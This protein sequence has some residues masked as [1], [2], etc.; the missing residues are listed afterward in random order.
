MAA[1]A[2]DLYFLKHFSFLLLEIYAYFSHLVPPSTTLSLWTL[3]Q[4]I[5]LIFFPLLLLA[6]NFPHHFSDLLF[7]V[8]LRSLIYFNLLCNLSWIH[9]PPLLA[10]SFFFYSIWI[11]LWQ[12]GGFP[13]L[14]F[15]NLPM[16]ALLFSDW[17][18]CDRFPL[19]SALPS[20][21][22]LVFITIHFQLAGNHLSSF[23]IFFFLLLPSYC[24]ISLSPLPSFFSHL[25][26]FWLE[27]ICCC[28]N[29]RPRYD[30]EI[31]PTQLFFISPCRKQPS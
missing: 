15:C 2:I 28:Y 17:S 29:L 7:L 20:P 14:T 18:F 23:S 30:T 26:L 16:Y 22:P 19:P 24:F 31:R 25:R 9:S 5:H 3:R 1:S 10:L 21:V 12:S 8:Y 27:M 13:H 6:I 11:F 4:R